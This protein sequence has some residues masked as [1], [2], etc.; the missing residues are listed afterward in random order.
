MINNV[1]IPGKDTLTLQSVLNFRDIGGVYT[2]DGKKVRERTVFRSA[3]PD[4]INAADIGKLH[5]LGI[6]TIIDLRSP[7]ENRSR[8]GGIDKIENVS[9]PLDFEAV[10]RE[11][12]IP[13]FYKKNSHGKIAEISNSIYLEILDAAIPVF[14]HIAEILITPDRCPVLIH[15]QAGKDRTGIICALIHMAAGTGRDAIVQDFMTS[16]DAI[17]PYYRKKLMARKI[18]S[19]GFF[20][21]DTVLYAI[22]VRQRNIESVM[23]RVEDHYGGIEGYLKLSG[24][25]IARLEQLRDRLLY[26]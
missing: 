19:I 10:T 17:I 5:Q 21:T 11:R 22:T 9:L 18:L 4:R 1:R 25:N 24:F 26:R 6:R 15:C 2:H 8:A 23:D 12:L 14:G 20:P 3:H 16:N 13:Y 7:E